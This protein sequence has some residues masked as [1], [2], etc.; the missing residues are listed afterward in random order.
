MADA[1]LVPAAHSHLDLGD[2]TLA[3]ALCCYH[4]CVLHCAQWLCR[5]A[6]SYPFCCG[7]VLCVCVCVFE[8]GKRG[9]EAIQT[10]PQQQSK[11]EGKKSAPKRERGKQDVPKWKARQNTTSK[12]QA[13]EK[14]FVVCLVLW[15]VRM[16]PQSCCCCRPRHAGC[17]GY[18]GCAGCAGCAGYAGYAG[19]DHGWCC[20][21]LMT[22]LVA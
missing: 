14:T 6:S 16:K 22:T 19:C 20:S 7:A 12:A 1:A 5:C 10:Q 4:C 8:G 21:C 13:T 11:K 2:D 15:L 3:A 17:A 18:A 9:R